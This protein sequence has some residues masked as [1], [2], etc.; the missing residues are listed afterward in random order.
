M[1]NKDKSDA[2]NIKTILCIKENLKSVYYQE[3]SNSLISFFRIVFRITKDYY[4]HSIKHSFNPISP[5]NNF[6][7]LQ[8][9]IIHH[10]PSQLY[11]ESIV[12]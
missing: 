7:P 3:R 1:F 5:F 6:F 12:S 11:T 9:V 8:K 4:Y 10:L 2:S